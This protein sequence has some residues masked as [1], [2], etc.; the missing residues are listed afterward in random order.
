MEN[1]SPKRSDYK[2]TWTALSEDYE[3]AIL[4]VTG[5]ASEEE[6]RKSGNTDANRIDQ[7]VS[8]DAGDEVLEIGCGVG[9]IGYALAD[10]C[11]KWVGADISSNMLDFAQKRLE[12]KTNTEF[13]ELSGCDLSYFQDS[14]FDIVYSSVVFM[15]LDE[16]DRYNYILESYRVLRKGGRVY[17]DNFNLKTKT[18]WTTFIQHKAI[19]ASDRPPH[20]SKSSTV[21]EFEAYLEHTSFQDFSVSEDGQWVVGFACK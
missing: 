16:W 8:F 5:V 13:V 17:F 2:S 6:L 4:H 15:H 12:S 21:H 3:S 20:I 1:N 11:K 7:F 18:G 14:S 9:R 10:R 19:P